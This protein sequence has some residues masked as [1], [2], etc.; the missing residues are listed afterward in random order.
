MSKGESILS[1]S[2]EVDINSAFLGWIYKNQLRNE[3][4]DPI[5][6]D[7]HYF[8][9]EPAS[10]WFP[11]QVAMKSAQVGW[12]T[13]AILKSLYALNYKKYNIIYTLPTQD[14]VED[15][16]P[17]KVNQM[18]SNNSVLV[19]T[20]GKNDAITKKEFNGNFIWYRGSFTKKAAIMHTADLVI[21][22]EVD[23]SDLGVLDLYASRTQYSKYKGEW[24]FS[25]PIVPGGIDQMYGQSDCRRWYIQ[26]SHCNEWQPLDYWVNVNKTKGI[27]QCRKCYGE[28]TPEDRHDGEWIAEYPS[29]SDL[30]HGYH[31]SQLMV[32]WVNAK[33]LIY[34]EETKTPQYFYNMILGLP[35]VIKDEI[36]N[37]DIIRSAVEVK[38]NNRLMNAMGVDVK[39]N[40]KH[41]VIGNHHGI[42]RVGV[43]AT[44]QEIEELRARYDAHIVV[45]ASPDFYARTFPERYPGKAW[46][47][48][49]RKDREKKE[50]IRWG[51]H[52]NKGVV[53]I[54]R[55][56]A[57]QMVIDQLKGKS[58][59]INTD[60]SVESFLAEPQMREYV[61]HFCNLYKVIEKDGLGIEKARWENSGDDDFVHATVY[62]LTALSKRPRTEYSSTP[63]LPWI[64]APVAPEVINDTMTGEP[65]PVLS[66]Q[67]R[68][69]DAW[70][71]P[72]FYD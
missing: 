7:N 15:F 2:A 4:D 69:E 36:V 51:D 54:D 23:A 1:R 68:G 6:F 72:S 39:H 46:F 38:V 66:R 29:R 24:K 9:I 8:L 45:D 58:L 42:F 32:S 31:V 40:R 35:Y 30:I 59:L 44:W 48:F 5:E 12:S 28:L 67:S 49:Y 16:V 26:C 34:L 62:F 65:L 63:F 22:D 41:Y 53:Y 64:S 52:N 25:N 27:F 10:D 11:K 57:I 50:V 61:K 19:N 13:L 71:Y 56:P 43:V 33:E 60:S 21:N 47:A 18:I 14:D 20:M 37:E 3:R 70:L 17:T 55:S